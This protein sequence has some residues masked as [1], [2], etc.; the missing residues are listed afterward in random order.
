MTGM[1]RLLA[2]VL[3]AI[4]CLAHSSLLAQET[5][6][7]ADEVLLSQVEK[8]LMSAKSQLEEVEDLLFSE[9]DDAD[10]KALASDLRSTIEQL[11]MLQSQFNEAQIP[12]ATN[13][14]D[15]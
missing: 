10:M 14:N 13:E 8:L 15:E 3:C 9:P 4:S 2:T 11:E 7:S 12:A 5:S 6:S 1:A